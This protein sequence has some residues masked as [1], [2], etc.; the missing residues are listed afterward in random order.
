MLLYSSSICCSAELNILYYI[1]DPL[2]YVHANMC[3]CAVWSVFARCSTQTDLSIRWYILHI[4]HK[5]SKRAFGNMRPA[6]FHNIVAHID[7]GPV[8]QSVV[9]LTSSLRVLVD[10]IQNILIFFAEINGSYSLFFSKKF[11]HICISLDVNFNESLTND[12]VSFEQTGPRF[13]TENNLDVAKDADTEDW[14]DCAYAP[15]YSSFGAYVRRYVFTRCGQYLASIL[16]KSISGRYR[17]DRNPVG[18]ITVQ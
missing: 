10:S 3:L 7:Q 13:F 11:Q 8:V 15:A 6:K 17:T 4:N 5:V 16:L 2:A 14:S 1:W 18:P 9:S 12:V